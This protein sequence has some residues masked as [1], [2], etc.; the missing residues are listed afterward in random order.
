VNT[1][2][3]TRSCRR[4]R[5]RSAA[6]SDRVTCHV[7]SSDLT[8]PPTFSCSSCAASGMRRGRTQDHSSSGHFGGFCVIDRY[9]SQ[10]R[11][12]Q[13]FVPGSRWA[14]LAVGSRLAYDPVESWPLTIRPEPR[15]RCHWR[16][17]I[18]G[19]PLPSGVASAMESANAR[20]RATCREF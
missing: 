3:I 2:H 8:S 13:L 11:K 19:A 10:W 15:L 16:N 20:R 4:G 18:C 7:D 9:P 5:R 14:V 6:S 12:R 17:T 1:E